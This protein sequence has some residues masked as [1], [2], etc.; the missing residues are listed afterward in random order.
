[1]HIPKADGV[2]NEVTK[3]INSVRNSCLPSKAAVEEEECNFSNIFET[4]NFT[5]DKRE[6]QEGNTSVDAAIVEVKSKTGTIFFK[7]TFFKG[8][9]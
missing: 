4:Y 1:M 3:M 2:S 9:F 6:I 5:E 8:K 7:I